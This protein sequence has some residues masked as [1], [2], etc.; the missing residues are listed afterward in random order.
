MSVAMPPGAPDLCQRV[1]NWT[2]A[3]AQ[4]Q[5]ERLRIGSVIGQAAVWL[6]REE[7]ASAAAPANAPLVAASHFSLAVVEA[8]QRGALTDQELMLMDA[9]VGLPIDAGWRV[10]PDSQ[11][12]VQASTNS[13]EGTKP[14]RVRPRYS[15]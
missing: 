3:F 2:A 13:T 4:A 8:R 9:P 7:V 15:P 5:M 11:N 6:S 1:R 12:P 14:G 10:R